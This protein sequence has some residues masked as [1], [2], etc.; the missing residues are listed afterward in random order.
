MKY[1]TINNTFIN[2][3]SDDL[4]EMPNIILYGPS[5]VGK[6]SEALKI[7]EKYSRSNLKYEK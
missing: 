4:N 6:Y 3:L 7:I 5:A 2:S 1:Q